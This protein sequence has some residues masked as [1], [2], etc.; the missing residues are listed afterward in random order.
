M[1]LYT[2]FHNNPEIPYP[3]ALYR[4]PK[5]LSLIKPKSKK[6]PAFTITDK[7]TIGIGQ[8]A[9]QWLASFL[10]Y[11]KEPEWKI[12]ENVNRL[13]P[14]N[15]GYVVGTLI[16]I[17]EKILICH[18]APFDEGILKTEATHYH[19]GQQI[20]LE[21]FRYVREV[22][23][24]EFEGLVTTIDKLV[25]KI[26]DVDFGGKMKVQFE[27]QNNTDHYIAIQGMD[28]WGHDIITDFRGKSLN[29]LQ[30]EWQEVKEPAEVE[31]DEVMAIR[32]GYGDYPNP[33]YTQFRTSCR[34][35]TI[36]L[37]ETTK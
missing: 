15:E 6:I 22:F 9:E 37:E 23:K 19:E 24:V 12:G 1:N 31:T 4:E 27:K 5:P 8:I 11:I 34:E 20:D 3:M 18:N 2:H 33:D 32:T 29:I 35:G 25:D 7:P 10:A 17:K 16:A 26:V 21:K 28:G 14:T 36:L 30:S 13:Y